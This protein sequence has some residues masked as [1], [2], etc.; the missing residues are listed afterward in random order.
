MRL[1]VRLEFHFS[2][3]HFYQ[4]KKWS[5]EKNRTVFGKCFTEFGHG[6]NYTLQVQGHVA[7]QSILP[8]VREGIQTT[9][10]QLD[11][12]HLNFDLTAFQNQIPTSEVICQYLHN[13]L[14]KLEGLTLS[15]V[16]LL[17]DSD[18][19]AFVVSN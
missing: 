7:N 15:Q 14:K 19:G 12:K 9:V 16:I 4:Q 5:E 8:R 6:H 11:H 1:E 18:L 10:D 2:S 17:E 13:E 3:A